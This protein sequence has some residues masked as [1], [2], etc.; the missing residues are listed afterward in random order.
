MFISALKTI[1][2]V[3]ANKLLVSMFLVFIIEITVFALYNFEH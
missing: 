3:I 1:K 2:K